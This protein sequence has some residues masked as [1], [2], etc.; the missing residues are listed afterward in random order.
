MSDWHVF[1]DVRRVFQFVVDFV[2]E[3]AMVAVAR[4]CDD[5]RIFHWEISDLHLGLLY[6][7]KETIRLQ[8]AVKYSRQ[9]LQGRI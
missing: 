7:N 5:A 1:L 4:E 9:H 8:E 3:S 2:E 6:L